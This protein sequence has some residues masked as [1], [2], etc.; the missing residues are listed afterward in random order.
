MQKPLVPTK[1]NKLSV[2]QK[3]VPYPPFFAENEELLR[4]KEVGKM[5][6]IEKLHISQRER[7]RDGVL[8][9]NK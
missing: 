3:F 5:K 4:K 9:I 6:N 7:E 2:T 1:Q 8:E